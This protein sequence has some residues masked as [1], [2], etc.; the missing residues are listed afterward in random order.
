MN[1]IRKSTGAKA[2]E[3][4]ERHGYWGEHPDY[5]AK[6]WE[7][8]VSEGYT[9]QGYWQW[10]VSSIEIDAENKGDANE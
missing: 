3:L 6:V 2:D 10:V 9:R 7:D 4:A 1:L 8:A 5:P